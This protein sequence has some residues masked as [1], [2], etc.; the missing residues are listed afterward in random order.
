MK[1]PANVNFTIMDNNPWEAIDSEL[2]ITDA[3]LYSDNRKHN[4]SIIDPNTGNFLKSKPTA[5]YNLKPV[6][7]KLLNRNVF[8]QMET[9]AR[10]DHPD[11]LGAYTKTLQ[12]L[13]NDYRHFYYRNSAGAVLESNSRFLKGDQ[14]F[15]ETLP[16]GLINYRAKIQYKLPLNYVRIGA[17]D[18]QQI[19]AGYANNTPGYGDR[20]VNA[21]QIKPYLFYLGAT[22]SSGNVLPAA[23]LN[24]A[25]HVKD[26]IAP[27]PYGESEELKNGVISRFPAAN[28][29][30]DASYI[31]DMR[32]LYAFNENMLSSAIVSSNDWAADNT[33]NIANTPFRALSP[34]GEDILIA[35]AN[36]EYT[37]QIEAGI[38]PAPS[39]D[40]VTVKFRTGVSDNA[41]IAT[42]TMRI[43]YF[44]TLAAV[45]SRT[46]TSSWKN[47]STESTLAEALP[48]E[49]AIVFRGRP[50][51]FPMAAPIAISASDNARDWDYYLGGSVAD[52]DNP[53]SDWVWGN[54]R[55]GSDAANTRTF[56][57][58]FP[59]YGSNLII[60]TIDKSIRNNN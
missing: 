15:S 58:S 45:Q 21:S 3:T 31:N 5:Q 14:S 25:L 32:K 33:G 6:F 17:N 28:N 54:V 8:M 60:R 51:D 20:N 38:P 40:N 39:E 18:S 7:A 37:A 12:P 52:P 24:L 50:D 57:T 9:S 56:R 19:P 48:D 26:V 53:W 27:F 41:G 29:L 13:S 44:D 2:G 4:D 23:K 36:A 47:T 30:T 22:D 43:R 35:F 59:V 49:T 42:S 16:T 46:L 11:G 1:N 10:I 34:M 55:W